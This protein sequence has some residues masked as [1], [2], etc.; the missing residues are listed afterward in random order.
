MTQSPQI[1]ITGG[2]GLLG[3]AVCEILDGRNIS[4]LIASHQ[5][6]VPPNG[7]YMDLST[8][9]G[10]EEAVSNKTVI[11]HLAS[12]KKQPN[13]DVQGTARLLHTIK[14]QG[15]TPHFIYISIVGVEELPLPYF[16]QKAQVEQL[17]MQ[18][19]LP[20]SIVKATQFHEYIDGLLTS[21]FKFGI[22]L[23]PKNVLVQPVSV[24]IAARA[25]SDLCSTKPTFLSQV[26]AGPEVLKL[27]DMATQW[28][29][30]QKKNKKY[31][32]FSLW[33]KAGKKLKAGVLTSP[34]NKQSGL[35]WSSWLKE[36]YKLNQQKQ[37]T[38]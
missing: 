32:S 37:A 38:F 35:T 25:L 21:F 31:I 19:G 7:V 5:E 34:K 27:Q 30:V 17:V 26:L 23:L 29:R 24:P 18:S 13:N 14:S 16:K 9:K 2:T 11:L 6:T 28:L 36:H 8:G 12:D 22:G 3:R 33:G 15:L 1:L 20:Y 10:M 4:Y